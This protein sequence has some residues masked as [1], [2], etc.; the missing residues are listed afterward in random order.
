MVGLEAGSSLKQ[1]L[2]RAAQGPLFAEAPEDG[3]SSLWASNSSSKHPYART[4]VAS[5]ALADVTRSPI[6]AAVLENCPTRIFLPNDRA[7]E[8]ATRAFYEAAGL[9]DRQVA[10]IG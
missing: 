10:L 9:N 3:S 8:P 4:S 5:Q 1:A 2:A 7:R 6:A